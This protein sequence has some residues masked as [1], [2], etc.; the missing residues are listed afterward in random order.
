MW[1][2]IFGGG[3]ES[4]TEEHEDALAQFNDLRK[5]ATSTSNSTAVVMKNLAKYF[6]QISYAESKFPVGDSIRVKFFWN[7]AFSHKKKNDR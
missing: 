4:G 6:E 7:N 2:S 5:R 1:S 3:K